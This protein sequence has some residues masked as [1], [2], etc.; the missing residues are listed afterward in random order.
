MVQKGLHTLV[1]FAAQAADLSFGYSSHVIPVACTRL[2]TER[3]LISPLPGAD[4]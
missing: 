4:L 3:V 2:S 1:D